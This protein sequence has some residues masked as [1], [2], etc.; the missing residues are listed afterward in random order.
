MW[1]HAYACDYMSVIRLWR[2]VFADAM[3]LLRSGIVLRT[4]FGFNLAVMELKSQMKPAKDGDA[5]RG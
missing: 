3:L 1:W 5:R 4:V 2:V